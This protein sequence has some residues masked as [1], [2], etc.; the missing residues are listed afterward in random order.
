MLLVFWARCGY[1][2]SDMQQGKKQD[3]SL[4]VEVR[5]GGLISDVIAKILVVE[6]KEEGKWGSIP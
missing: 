3:I 6:K 5:D 1:E 2:I 4:A